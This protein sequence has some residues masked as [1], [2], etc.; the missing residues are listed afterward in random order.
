MQPYSCILL[1]HPFGCINIM[2]KT[3]KALA[4]NTRRQLLDRLLSDPGLSVS[5]LCSGLAM[6]RQSVSKHLAILEA[7]NLVSVQWLGREKLYYLNPVPIA[8]I[9]NRWLDKFSVGKASALVS[10]R[11]ALESPQ[12][13]QS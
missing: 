5:G 12:G 1:V 2:D 10:L 4:D 13:D 8:E 7:A 6:R 9:S 3:F 11:R